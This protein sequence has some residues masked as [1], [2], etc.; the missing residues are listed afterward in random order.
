MN[1]KTKNRN[2]MLVFTTRKIVSA[3]NTLGEKNFEDAYFKAMNENDLDA[4]SKIIYT[5]AENEENGSKAFK[6]S[7]EVYDFMDEYKLEND[8]TY[9][10]IFREVAEAINDEGF[11]KNKMGQEE[12]A[13]KISNPLLGVNMD[14]IIKQ[15]AEK[16]I[17]KVAEQ[18]IMAQA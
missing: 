14:E 2:I 18:Q 4:L 12:L 7:E 11:F 1:L 15:S 8:K 3:S 13:Q 9:E 10:D 17:S 6:S 5:F 16:A